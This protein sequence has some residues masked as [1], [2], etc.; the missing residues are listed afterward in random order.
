MVKTVKKI[1]WVILVCIEFTTKLIGH[2]SQLVWVENKFV[3]ASLS[4]ETVKFKISKNKFLL[5]CTI[6]DYTQRISD[7]ELTDAKRH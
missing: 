1:I 3:Q 2:K 5:K 7:V 6:H 4:L